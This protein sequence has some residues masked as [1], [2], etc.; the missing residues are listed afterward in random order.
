VEL[1]GDT[2]AGFISNNEFA[3]VE[4]YA[5]WCGH[6]KNLV[7]EFSRLPG[8]LASKVKKPVAVGKIDAAEHKEASTPY[9]V[10]GFPSLRL[11]V[12]GAMVV[13]T[14]KSQPT[15][16]S[17]A[18]WIGTKLQVPYTEL[19]DEAAARAFVAKSDVNVVGF[20]GGGDAA[21]AAAF[22]AGFAGVSRSVDAAAVGLV[23]TPTD[24]ATSAVAAA[25]G[26]A[27]SV[28]LPAVAVLTPGERFAQP[29]H[30]YEGSLSNT[31]TFLDF[32]A[33]A[34]TPLVRG[35]DTYGRQLMKGAGPPVAVLVFA[36]TATDKVWE[37]ARRTHGKTAVVRVDISGSNA[38]AKLLDAFGAGLGK[39]ALAIIK[40][41]GMNKFAY[42]ASTVD[43]V[44]KVV[45]FVDGILD[46][47]IKPELKSAAAPAQAT[48]A[49]LTT[50]VGS[51]FDAVVRT[52]T[53]HALVEFYAP[54]CGHC[55][56]LAPVW[57][58]VARAFVGVPN[59]V[60]AKIDATANDVEGH[61]VKSY[62][63]L[64]YFGPGSVEEDYSGGRTAKD[65]I[66]FLKAKLGA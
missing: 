19:A 25:L 4:F 9:G 60:V 33:G 27:A 54:W 26:V 50:L 45:T 62:P 2:L 64:K 42:S 36:D 23:S 13:L 40:V 32:V 28:A 65:F 20:V 7:P 58:E 16:E 17:L 30:I 29:V 38:N 66:A 11:F 31:T 49:G 52:P 56:S 53:T 41:K 10:T 8:V 59:A 46:G 15:A 12:D 5:P 24:A 22:V 51:T 48:V 39:E 61:S 35:W 57:E 6:C 21:A 18:T 34:T 3:F 63:T 44:D 37:L 43:D 47:S 1:T 55:K 14:L